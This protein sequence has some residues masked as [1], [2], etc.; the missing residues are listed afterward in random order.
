[1]RYGGVPPRLR[2]H[3]LRRPGRPATYAAASSS[4]SSA[5]AASAGADPSAVSALAGASA[6]AAAG[7]AA[8]VSASGGTTASKVIEE[9]KKY[10]GVKYVWGGESPKGFDCSGLT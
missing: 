9:A 6:T 10:L 4:E 3:R 7:G 2:G 8:G 1:M 5:A